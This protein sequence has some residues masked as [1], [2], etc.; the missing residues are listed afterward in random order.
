[1][2]LLLI[3]TSTEASAGTERTITGAVVSASLPVV[4]VHIKSLAM[5]LFARSFTPVVSV[6]VYR[7]SKAKS[8][9]GLKVATVPLK[10][11]TPGITTLPALS[12]KVPELMVL[13]SMF[14]LMVTVMLLLTATAVAA[15]MGRMDAMRGGVTSGA[16]PVV[17][18]QTLASTKAFPTRSFTPTLKVAV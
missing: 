14:S 10:L 11:T 16:I 18:L 17:K 8:A 2:T 6:A 12:I 15:S 1:M 5:A 7:V 3:A 9:S 4:K 13:G